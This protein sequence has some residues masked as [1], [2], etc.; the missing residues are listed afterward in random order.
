MKRVLLALA[1]VALAAGCSREKA[2]PAEPDV[3][4][5]EPAPAVPAPPP[6]P[7]PPRQPA[8]VA[9][10]AADEADDAPDEDART[11]DDADATGLTTRAAPAPSE[12][13]QAPDP[14]AGA[15]DGNSSG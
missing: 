15:A 12:D 6:P 2:P 9:T 11:Q 7:V 5:N 3:T 14:A 4:V 8:P 10:N 13:E 1:A